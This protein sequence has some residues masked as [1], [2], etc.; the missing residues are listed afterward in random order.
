MLIELIGG[1]HNFTKKK[2]NHRSQLLGQSVMKY[3]M[4]YIRN[5]ATLDL[6]VELMSV[7]SVEELYEK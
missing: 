2:N 7:K 6:I 4:G 5:V 1:V 3:L